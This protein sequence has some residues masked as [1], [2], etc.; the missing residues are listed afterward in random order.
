[1][2][3]GEA[4]YLLQTGETLSMP[5]SRP[6]PAVARGVHELRLKDEE[7]IYRVFYAV[8]QGEALLVFHAFTKK[9]QKTPPQEIELAR[10]RLQL[11]MQDERVRTQF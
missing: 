10:R 8:K 5:L 1:M 3:L 7:G 6:M 9:T 11:L 4:L 2:S